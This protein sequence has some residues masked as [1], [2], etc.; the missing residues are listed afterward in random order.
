[1]GNGNTKDSLKSLER[2]HGVVN[3]FQIRTCCI[4]KYQKNARGRGYYVWNRWNN[5]R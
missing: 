3:D 1:M 2:F 5:K 4:E